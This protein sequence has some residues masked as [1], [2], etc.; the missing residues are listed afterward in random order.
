MSK[1]NRIV[2]HTPIPNKDAI[3]MYEQLK[4]RTKNQA[5][6]IRTIIENDITIS[7]SPAGTGKTNLA[8]GLA[9]EHL[10]DGKIKR[11]IILRPTVEASKRGLGY[12][13]GDYQDKLA[14]Y[15]TPLLEQMEYYIGKAK[16]EFLIHSKVIQIDA[17]EFFRGRNV[18]DA[19]LILDEAQNATEKQLKLVMTRLCENSKLIIIGDSD[20]VDLPPNDAGGLDK[21]IKDLDG[22]EGLGIAKMDYSDVQRLPIVKR[23]LERFA[24][25]EGKSV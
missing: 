17:V 1:K 5:N 6:F 4:P 14:P 23:I 22:I 15:M 8:V 19:Y 24:E 10:R 18:T 16:L 20:Q 7:N 25:K 11:I 12:L 3:T 9:L 21:I 2:K 13:K